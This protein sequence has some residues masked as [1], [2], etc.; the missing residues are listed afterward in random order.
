M[1][2][3]HVLIFAHLTQTAI[4]D[5]K[6]RIT[7]NAQHFGVFSDKTIGIKG[8]K[9]ALNVQLSENYFEPKT[10]LVRGRATHSKY[11]IVLLAPVY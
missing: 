4:P 3:I 5:N 11:F 7:F 1:L 6:V 8:N 9:M 10:N 2:I